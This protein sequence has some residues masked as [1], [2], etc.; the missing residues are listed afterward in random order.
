[1]FKAIH[2][3]LIC[4]SHACTVC[5]EDTVATLVLAVMFLGMLEAWFPFAIKIAND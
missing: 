2:C 1:M 4:N 5:H 3:K